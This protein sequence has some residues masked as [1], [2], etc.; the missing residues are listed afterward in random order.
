[1]L[2]PQQLNQQDDSVNHTSVYRQKAF[3][4]HEVIQTNATMAVVTN[5]FLVAVVTKSCL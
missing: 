5:K 1:M 2:T 3:A 4:T